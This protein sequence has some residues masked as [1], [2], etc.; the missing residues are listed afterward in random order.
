MVLVWL[1]LPHAGPSG[2]AMV[3][4]WLRLS[5]MRQLDWYRNR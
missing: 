1:L 2:M 5:A 4:V 3:F